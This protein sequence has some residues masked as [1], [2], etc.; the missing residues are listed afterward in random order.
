MQHLRYF[1]YKACKSEFICDSDNLNRNASLQAT[2]LFFSVWKY[3]THFP[4]KLFCPLPCILHLLLCQ[5]KISL[6]SY[7][8]FIVIHLTFFRLFD[9]NSFCCCICPSMSL[10]KSRT[11][12]EWNE[13]KFKSSQDRELQDFWTPNWIF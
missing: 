10:W 4:T 13:P 2:K 8:D 7:N 5:R 3:V 9:C 12:Y 11:M 1:I 6:N